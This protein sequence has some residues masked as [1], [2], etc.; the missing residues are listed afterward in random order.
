MRVELVTWQRKALGLY[1]EEVAKIQTSAQITCW[2]ARASGSQE[3]VHYSAWPILS[4][5]AN[6]STAYVGISY[7]R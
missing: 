3:K 4:T 5:V 7:L 2:Q 6:G 1:E